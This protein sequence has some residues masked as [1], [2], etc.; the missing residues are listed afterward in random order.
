MVRDP[1]V[2]LKRPKVLS[3]LHEGDDG[4]VEVGRHESFGRAAELLAGDPQDVL[5]MPIREHVESGFISF[6][7]HLWDLLDRHAAHLGGPPS[8]GD[9]PWLSPSRRL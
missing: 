6:L 4:P 8:R 7:R 5:A 1:T 9:L 2:G 3:H